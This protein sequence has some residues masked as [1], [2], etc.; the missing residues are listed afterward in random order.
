MGSNDKRLPHLTCQV[1]CLLKHLMSVL[2]L[3]QNVKYPNDIKVYRNTCALF[4]LFGLYSLSTPIG[5][6]VIISI[7][8]NEIIKLTKTRL[9]GA[10]QAKII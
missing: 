8:K 6:S 9:Y 2:K 1:K 4:I 5:P 3:H 10:K 7:E